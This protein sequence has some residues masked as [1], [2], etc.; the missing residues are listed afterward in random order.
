[1]WTCILGLWPL[2][3]SR[4]GGELVN[5]ILYYC[6]GELVNRGR[7]GREWSLPTHHCCHHPSHCADHHHQIIS[8]LIISAHFSTDHHSHQLHNNQPTRSPPHSCMLVLLMFEI[9]LPVLSLL[10]LLYYFLTQIGWNNDSKVIKVVKS[11]PCRL[12]TITTHLSPPYML[13]SSLKL[14]SYSLFVPSLIYLTHF[15]L[16]GLIF[17]PKWSA[18]LHQND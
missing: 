9:P 12:I 6:T 4:R 1:M 13:T 14:S 5:T 16:C 3:A 7:Q 2:K 17:D 11:S 15:N 8:S 18:N 10:G